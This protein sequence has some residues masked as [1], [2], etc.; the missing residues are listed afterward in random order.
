M[1]VA[2]MTLLIWGP[3]IVVVFGYLLAVVY[4][5]HCDEWSVR[6]WFVDL[7][8]AWSDPEERRQMLGGDGLSEKLKSSRAAH[9]RQSRTDGWVVRSLKHSRTE[10][11]NSAPS[12]GLS[13]QQ[14][15]RM[16]RIRHASP[17][18]NF[19]ESASQ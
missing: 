12:T 15:K 16:E 3:P 14:I 7:A 2:D 1:I 10:L 4:L 8:E 5:H 18:V 13:D 17:E 6:Q 19:E 9:I 11:L